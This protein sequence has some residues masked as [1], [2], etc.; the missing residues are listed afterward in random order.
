MV[1]VIKVERSFNRVRGTSNH[2]TLKYACYR[3]VAKKFKKTMCF[4]LYK[5]GCARM[6]AT[7]QSSRY[8]CGQM[9]TGS[10]RYHNRII[11]LRINHVDPALNKRFPSNH[12]NGELILGT[13]NVLSLTSRSS[14]L[15]Q[16]SQ[17]I[18]E[19]RLDLLRITSTHIPGTD[20]ELMDNGSLL[21]YSGRADGIRRQGIGLSLLKRIKNSLISYMPIS[22]R[23]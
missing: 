20:T 9:G 5:D 8:L 12:V 15:F 3:N 7:G 1:L 6:K 14:Q 21:I 2:S 22:E 10:T 19:Y 11:S 13:W 17:C 16:L 23:M 18:S 4:S